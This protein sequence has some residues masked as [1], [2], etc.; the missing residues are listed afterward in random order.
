MEA[1]IPSLS[2]FSRSPSNY[3]SSSASSTYTIFFHPLH[4][5]HPPSISNSKSCSS[6]LAILKSLPNSASNTQLKIYLTF[7]RHYFYCH[8]NHLPLPSL[9]LSPR[10]SKPNA[11]SHATSPTPNS[12]ST[13]SPSSEKMDVDSATTPKPKPTT[14]KLKPTLTSVP[15][16][17]P[18][19]I[20]IPIPA[21]AL[22]TTPDATP[23]K[24]DPYSTNPN[25]PP[26]YLKFGRNELIE[27]YV[28]LKKRHKIGDSDLVDLQKMQVKNCKICVTNKMA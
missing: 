24:N 7:L 16:P 4:P 25:F 2:S 15:H 20:P 6:L 8:Y 10:F 14:P 1:R 12:T 19:P 23:V 28:E 27:D 26:T 17:T 22:P 9:T 11:T 5:F 18:V 3:P 13:S 21:S